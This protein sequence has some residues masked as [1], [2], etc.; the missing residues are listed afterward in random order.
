MPLEQLAPDLKPREWKRFVVPVEK[1]NASPERIDGIQFQSYKA[2]D[3]PLIYID[4]VAFL[5]SA[6]AGAPKT[7]KVE[8]APDPELVKLAA[9][10]PA[11]AAKAIEKWAKGQ[12]VKLE[13]LNGETVE[14]AVVSVDALRVTVQ[15]DS[16][17]LD[18][19]VAEI[20]A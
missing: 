3:R 7:A 1:L 16:G 13:V 19:P 6:S 10:V 12:K 17:P 4:S 5:R 14:G 2:S 18:V 8:P 15:R 9:V 20:A 11:E